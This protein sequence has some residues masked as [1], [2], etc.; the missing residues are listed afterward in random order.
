MSEKISVELTL[1][2]ASLL[3]LA[4]D[5]TARIGYFFGADGK[6]HELSTDGRTNLVNGRIAIEDAVLPVLKRKYPDLY[7]QA[8][9]R[10]NEHVRAHAE[11]GPIAPQPEPANPRE[12]G[13]TGLYL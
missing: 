11:Q 10:A 7:R 3:T 5:V 6:V 9:E 8:V 2:E 12:P 4:A 1:I 13:P